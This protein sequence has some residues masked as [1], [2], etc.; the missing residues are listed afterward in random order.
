MPFENWDIV[1]YVIMND[2]IVSHQFVIQ[3]HPSLQSTLYIGNHWWACMEAGNATSKTSHLSFHLF[4]RLSIF[5]QILKFTQT[6]E[7]NSQR[8]PHKLKLAEVWGLQLA[9]WVV[10]WDSSLLLWVIC[11]MPDQ[12]SWLFALP[13][14]TN[15]QFHKMIH[16]VLYL[17]SCR[18]Y[19]GSWVSNLHHL[20]RE[21]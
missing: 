15:G 17:P 20:Q 21:S 11:H 1:H 16:V 4:N 19:V 10:Q 8:Y 18:T 13:V 12:T 2:V 9:E 14:R 3:S 5:Y 7:E 6:P